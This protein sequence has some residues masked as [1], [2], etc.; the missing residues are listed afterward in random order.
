MF[1]SLLKLGFHLTLYFQITRASNVVQMLA[2]YNEVT[3]SNYFNTKNLNRRNIE[4]VKIILSSFF[5][6]KVVQQ[7]IWD[8]RDL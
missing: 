2:Y 6:Y 1:G 8:Y 5:K 7:I 4:T 3:S